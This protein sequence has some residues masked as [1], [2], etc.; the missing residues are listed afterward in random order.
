MNFYPN[1]DGSAWEQKLFSYLLHTSK[2]KP[3]S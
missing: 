1:P 3:P 2:L